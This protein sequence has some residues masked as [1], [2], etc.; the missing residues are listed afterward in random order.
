MHHF[1]T[2]KAYSLIRNFI[3]QIDNSIKTQEQTVR[4]L[5]VLDAISDIIQQTPLSTTIGRFANPAMREVIE[6]IE[7][8]TENPYLRNSFG[9]KSRLD[10]G[11]GHELNFLCYLF[12][13]SKEGEDSKTA[14]LET[15]EAL[16]VIKQYFNTVRGY[17]KK[18][19]IEAAGS[20]GCWSIDDYLLLPYLFGSSEMIREVC[21]PGLTGNGLFGQASIGNP[22]PVL[23]GLTRHSWAEVNVYLI[24][25]YDKE[26]LGRN[27]VTQHFI[28]STYLPE[29]VFR[30][31]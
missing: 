28:Y 14:K 15:Y 8:I 9:N 29:T 27:V 17:I 24:K 5:P 25:T 13:I 2:T 12:C 3:F 1:T 10:F 4:G 11:T 22:S 18:F 7:S 16:S 26:V 21:P 20:H 23:K 31:A 30:E 19:N 6:K